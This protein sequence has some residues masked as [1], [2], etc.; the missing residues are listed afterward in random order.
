MNKNMIIKQVAIEVGL[1]VSEYNGFDRQELT[2][3]QQC[4][5][6]QLVLASIEWIDEHVGMIP[7]EARQDMMKDFGFK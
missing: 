4:F 2:A 3:G 1:V 6:E 7:F 5:A